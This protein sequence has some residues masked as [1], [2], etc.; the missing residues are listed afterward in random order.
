MKREELV[1]KLEDVL[2]SAGVPFDFVDV[3]AQ[4]QVVEDLEH[5]C[6][7][8]TVYL[9][10]DEPVDEIVTPVYDACKEDT[11][12]VKVMVYSEGSKVTVIDW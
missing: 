9:V 5:F 11:E 6:V 3:D 10:L 1:Q 4:F 2:V 7:S 12:P 8:A